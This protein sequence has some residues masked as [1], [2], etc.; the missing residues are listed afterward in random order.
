MNDNIQHVITAVF[1][2]I[3]IVAVACHLFKKDD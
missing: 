3:A 1:V 2:I